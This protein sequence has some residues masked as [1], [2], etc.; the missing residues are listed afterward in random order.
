MAAQQVAPAVLCNIAAPD[1]GLVYKK[2]RMS[3]EWKQ[4]FLLARV[5]L[6]WIDVKEQEACPEDMRAW[7]KG[8]NIAL[9]RNKTLVDYDA[10]YQ[11]TVQHEQ[12]RKEFRADSQELAA[13]WVAALQ[14]RVRPWAD[15]LQSQHERRLGSLGGIEESGKLSGPLRSAHMEIAKELVQMLGATAEVMKELGHTPLAGPVLSLLGLALEVV[16]RERADL[17]SL[18]TARSNLQ[19]ITR[20]TMK[21]INRALETGHDEYKR[22]LLD[23]L[24]SVEQVARQL[25]RYELMSTRKRIWHAVWNLK[26]GPTTILQLIQQCENKLNK[27]V[28]YHAGEVVEDTAEG[29]NEEWKDSIYSLLVL[30]ICWIDSTNS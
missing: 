14:R 21:A 26:T 29:E 25:E 20:H 10:E 12:E 24:L 28:I 7:R 6:W 19:D 22:E 4:V 11:W 30:L 1:V 3:G 5:D 13:L 17:E 27:L 16:H 15:V 8:H 18:D 23:L 9:V 2:T